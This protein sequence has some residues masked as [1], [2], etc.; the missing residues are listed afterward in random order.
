MDLPDF[1]EVGCSPFDLGKLA[2][3]CKVHNGSI[4]VKYELGVWSGE[5][6]LK[7]WLW[8]YRYSHGTFI[9]TMEELEDAEELISMKA[10]LEKEQK[11]AEL[12]EQ[13]ERARGE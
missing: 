4:N 6:E 5:Y 3:W 2:S 8:S 11:I 7:V 9:D 13:L 1:E 12:T 10:N